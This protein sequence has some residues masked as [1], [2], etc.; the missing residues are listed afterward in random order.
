MSEGLRHMFTCEDLLGENHMIFDDSRARAAWNG[1]RTAVPRAGM[2]KY[3]EWRRLI[4]DEGRT[5]GDAAENV[6][7]LHY[8]R[9]KGGAEDFYSIRLT[10]KHRVVFS[11]TGEVVTVYTIG[12]HY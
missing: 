4:R 5:P 6:G 12:G 2:R 11:V 1:D 7:D 8:E 9:L 3:Y 10:Q